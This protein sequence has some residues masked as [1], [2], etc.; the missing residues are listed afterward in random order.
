MPHP[1]TKS[2]QSMFATRLET[3]THLLVKA[4][5]FFT[6]DASFLQLRIAP[7]MAT[8]GTQIAYTCNQPR[9]YALW[10]Q[11]KPA[12]NLDTNV[13]TVEQAR[14]YI[15]D[16]KTL[17][18]SAPPDDSKLAATKR[19]NFGTNLY[20]DLSGEEYVNDFLIPNLYFHLVTAYDILRMAGMD[21]GKSDYM[22]HLL[23]RVRQV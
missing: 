23:P 7:D 20:A 8:F 22:L 4:E 1:T 12:D 21:I 13:T 6:S 15:S 9:N 2:F 3:L 16:T 14:A 19:F 11:G 18:L 5:E 10:L 17:L